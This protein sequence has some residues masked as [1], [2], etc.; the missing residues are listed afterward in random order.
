MFRELHPA[1]KISVDDD[2]DD[3]DADDEDGND[4]ATALRV[5]SVIEE[6]EFS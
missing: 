3:D 1:R 5:T 6:A 2:D 4:E